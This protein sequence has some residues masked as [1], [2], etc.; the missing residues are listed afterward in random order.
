MINTFLS[1]N[2][3]NRDLSRSLERVQSQPMVQRET[4][5]YLANIGNVTSIEE[6]VADDRLFRYAM[7]AHGLE[8]MAYAKAFMVKV[9]EEGISDPESF[10]NKLTD[11]RYVEFARTYNFVAGG[12]STTTY[13]P[14]QKGTIDK[15]ITFAIRNGTS[16]NDEQLLADINH[17]LA[18]I[19]QVKSADDL[20]ADNRL[21]TVAMLAHGF[22]DEVIDKQVLKQVLEGGIDDPESPANRMEDKRFAALAE[23]FNFARYGEDATTYNVTQA[24][25]IDKYLRQTLEEDAGEQNEGVR[26]ALYFQRKGP[27]LRSYYEILADKALSRVVRTALGFPEALAQ[28]DID[29]QVEMIKDRI[30]LTDFQDP[31]KLQAFL[32]RFTTLWELENPSN[33][34]QTSIAALFSQPTEYGISTDMLFTIAQLKR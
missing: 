25:T 2:L 14:A 23:S 22:T 21:L 18:K 19:P 24:P 33:P 5:Y 30:D 29:K 9:L 27:E 6:F 12:A 10:A 31:E 11:K 32:T 28:A 16:P 4:E 15:Y 7:K 26:L 20:L 8:D 1:F 34:Q 17:Y 3:I 13:N